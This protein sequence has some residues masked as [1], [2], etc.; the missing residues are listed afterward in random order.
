MTN[1]RG[2]RKGPPAKNVGVSTDP[3]SLENRLTTLETKVNI[4]QWVLGIVVAAGAIQL[5]RVLFSS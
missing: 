2:S 4:F 5:F 1:G 3:I